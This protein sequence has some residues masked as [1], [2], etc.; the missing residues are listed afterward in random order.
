[1]ERLPH[2]THDRRLRRALACFPAALLCLIV[3]GLAYHAG[4]GPWVLWAG[5][6][7]ALA[8]A[9]VLVT[10]PINSCRC[11]RCGRRLF[12]P[13]DTAEFPCEHC[14]VAWLTRA[15]GGGPWE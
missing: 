8:A 6:A 1:V 12:R 2:P 7:G 14:Q 9:A 13:A 4:A 5:L 11:P 10:T 15:H 3:P